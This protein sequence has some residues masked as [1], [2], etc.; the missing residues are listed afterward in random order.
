MSGSSYRAAVAL[1]TCLA[2]GLPLWGAWSRRQQLPRCAL[3][4]APIEPIYAVEIVPD[5]GPTLKFC[6]LR[7]ADFWCA[8]QSA[9]PR[10]ARVTDEVSGQPLDAGEAFFARSSIVTT[11]ATGNRIHAF[12]RRSDAEAHAA[13]FAGRVLSGDLLPLVAGPTTA[14]SDTSEE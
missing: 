2:V 11:P 14:P 12:A 5:D 13:E 7:C 4:G 1:V 6:C 8:R 10:E 3:D 9:P